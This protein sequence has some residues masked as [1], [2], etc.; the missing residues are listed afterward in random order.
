M[1]SDLQ[2]LPREELAKLSSAQVEL[3]DSTEHEPAQSHQKSCSEGHRLHHSFSHELSGLPAALVIYKQVSEVSDEV[4]STN[5]N[6]TSAS[7]H[8]HVLIRN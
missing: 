7:V 5:S 4:P 1:S 2:V 6:D 3:C 8:G